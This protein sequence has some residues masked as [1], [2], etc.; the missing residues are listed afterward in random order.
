MD[1]LDKKEQ[2]WVNIVRDEK[3]YRGST[4]GL[5]YKELEAALPKGEAEKIVKKALN[6]YAKAKAKKKDPEPFDAEAWVRQGNRL[7]NESE[8]EH[9]K[10]SIVLKM[11]FCPF[12]EGLK[13]IGLSKEEVAH[14]CDVASITDYGKAE[15]HGMRVKVDGGLAKGL[16]VCK[17]E[18]FKD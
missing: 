7:I 15:A 14:Y 6:E 12:V 1:K 9:T 3:K 4:F 2:E 16:D 11:K 8:V 10:N 17:L 5:L 18:I 13:E